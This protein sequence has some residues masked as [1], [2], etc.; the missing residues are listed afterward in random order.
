MSDL[1]SDLDLD[2]EFLNSTEPKKSSKPSPPEEEDVNFDAELLY[3][4]QGLGSQDDQ[5]VFVAAESVIGPSTCPLPPHPMRG[6]WLFRFN[7]SVLCSQS[8]FEACGT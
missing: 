2:E 7:L 5:G 6:S 8:R 1:D 4:I 3:C